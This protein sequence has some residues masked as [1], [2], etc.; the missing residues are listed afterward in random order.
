[1][2]R[3]GGRHD[4]Y[5]ATGR[6]RRK[7]GHRSTGRVSRIE[8]SASAGRRAAPVD[9]TIGTVIGDGGGNG[10]RPVR[11]NCGRRRRTHGNRNGGRRRG[12]PT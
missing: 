5:R 12:G 9:A 8:S 6:G 10:C 3:G 2:I 7:R 4:G 1:M 11:S